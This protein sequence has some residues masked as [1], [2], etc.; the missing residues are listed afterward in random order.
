MTDLI[1]VYGTL[2]RGRA[3]H[4]LLTRV[5]TYIGSE[6]LNGVAMYR[7]GGCGFPIAVFN[8][9]SILHAEVYRLH[10]PVLLRQIDYLEGYE[11]FDEYN[12]L[13]IRKIV[14]TTLGN[15]WIYMYNSDNPERWKEDTPFDKIVF[16]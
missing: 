11:E 10:D 15:A 5:A 9:G 3:N 12:S 14:K 13:F 8:E 1:C 2:K 4:N 6:I 16:W 7:V